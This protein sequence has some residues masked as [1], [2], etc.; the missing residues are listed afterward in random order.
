MSLARA[1]LSLSG[2][3]RLGFAIGVVTATSPFTVQINGDTV[4]IPS[5]NRLASYTPALNDVVLV[6]RPGPGFLVVNKIV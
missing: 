5:P 4:D 2:R 1:L 3:E 6:L